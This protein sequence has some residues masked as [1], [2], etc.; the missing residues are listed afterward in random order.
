MHFL[1]TNEG[2]WADPKVLH[3]I[4]VICMHDRCHRVDMYVWSG[5]NSD[6]YVINSMLKQRIQLNKLRNMYEGAMQSE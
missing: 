2:L 5:E 3:S 6:F 4:K 1:G